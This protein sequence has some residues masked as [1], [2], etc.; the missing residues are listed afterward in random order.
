MVAHSGKGWKLA[1]SLVGLEAEAN[2]LAPRRSQ[3]S[4]GSIGDAAHRARKSDH[5]PDG[6]WV[7]A[8]DLTHDPAG[9][10]DAHAHARRIAERR[11]PRVKYVISNGRIWHPGVGWSGYGGLN[12][13]RTHLHIS[14]HHTP[15]AR[16][17]LRPWL[18]GVPT[19]P[20]IHRPTEDDEMGKFIRDANT[21]NIFHVY[22]ER[23]RHLSPPMWKKR[24]FLGARAETLPGETVMA[25]LGDLIQDPT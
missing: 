5:N 3:R 24:E 16:G 17:D 22:G 12:P 10:F 8:I 9:G 15:A 11:D 23:F 25:L 14:I 6:G 4:D 21:G 1:P 19:P 20:P 7:H 18:S 2:R 13:H